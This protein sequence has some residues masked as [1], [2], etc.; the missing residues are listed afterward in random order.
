[1]ARHRLFRR[2]ADFDGVFLHKKKLNAVDAWNLRRHSRKIIY[3]FDDAIMYSYKRPGAYSRAHSVP[4]CRTV[5]LADMT[6]VGSF[7]LA[8]KARPLNPNT[9]VLPLGL[10]SRDYGLDAKPASDGRV[11]LVWIG[12]KSTLPYLETVRPAL[13]RVAARYGNLVIRVIGDGFPSW[14]GVPI[15]H[16]KWSPQTRRTGLATSDIGLAPLPDDPFTR[17]KCSFKVLEYSA[18]SL[19]VVGSPVGTNV[20][21]IVE[22]QTGLLATTEEEWVGCLTRLIENPALRVQMGQDGRIHAADYDVQVVGARLTKLIRQ[23]LEGN[24]PEAAAERQTTH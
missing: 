17:G 14:P 15:E 2:A 13:H 9:D 10:D 12:S 1:M 4:F 16:L 5:R 20:D 22:G 21:H 24:H 6:L 23:C 8:E 11:R 19:P 7:Y 18:S 3:N